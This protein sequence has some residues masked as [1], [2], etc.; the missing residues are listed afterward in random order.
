MWPGT[1]DPY[2]GLGDTECRMARE[3]IFMREMSGS[4]AGRDVEEINL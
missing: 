3:F 1:R 4:E 2:I